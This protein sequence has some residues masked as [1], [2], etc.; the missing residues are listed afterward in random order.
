MGGNGA[1]VS[2]ANFMAER[3]RWR[4]ASTRLAFDRYSNHRAQQMALVGGW[5][6]ERLAVLGA[7][8]CNDLDLTTLAGSFREIHLFDIDAQALEGAYRRQS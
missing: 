6:G 1:I 2:A 3:E 8:N 5:R 4:N 7:G